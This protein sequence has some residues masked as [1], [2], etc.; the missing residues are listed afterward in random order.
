MQVS[1]PTSTSVYPLMCPGVCIGMCACA[2]E[3]ILDEVSLEHYLELEEFAYQGC[4]TDRTGAHA[5]AA[6]SS[7]RAAAAACSVLRSSCAFCTMAQPSLF[8]RSIQD[9]G[10][11]N[12][13]SSAAASSASDTLAACPCSSSVYG[14]LTAAHWNRVCCFTH[15]SRLDEGRCVLARP[16]GT[17]LGARVQACLS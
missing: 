5:S 15:V 3:R 1:A 17:A 2:E 12:P 8:R 13:K 11:G 9:S 10:R 7:P 4:C 6:H 14:C 16:M